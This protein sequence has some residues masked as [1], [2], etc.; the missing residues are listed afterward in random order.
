MTAVYIFI[1]AEILAFLIKI[2]SMYFSGVFPCALLSELFT[3]IYFYSPS[4]LLIIH[5]FYSYIYKY[6]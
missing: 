3:Y 6:E 2:L 4:F 1:Y 5:T